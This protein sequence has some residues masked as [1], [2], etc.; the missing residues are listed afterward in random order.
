MPAAYSRLLNDEDPAVRARAARD[1]CDWEEAIVPTN[2]R[3]SPRYA[4]PAFRYGFARMV[5][6]YWAN[7]CFLPYDGV[8]LAEASRL[9]HVPGRIIQGSLDLTNLVGSPWLLAAAWPGSELVLIDD[10]G[11]GG[12]ATLLGAI[13]SATN[14]FGAEG[15]GRG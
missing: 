7:D 14:S 2:P 4:D 11:H 15:D 10:A 12:N 8:L 5:T 9:R 6:R 1:W 3:P 13:V